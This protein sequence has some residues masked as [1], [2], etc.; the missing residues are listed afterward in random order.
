[1]ATEPE[2]TESSLEEQLVAY[3]D[4]ELDAE[5]VR[6]I[7]ERLATE[8]EV[9]DA[10]NRLERTWDMLDELGSTP[11]GES[12][13]RTTLEMVTVAAEKDVEQAL[14]KVPMRR[15][16]RHWLIGAGILSAVVVGFFAVFLAMPNANRQLLEDL[17][18]I[19]NL[20]EYREVDDISFLRLMKEKGLSSTF[21]AAENPVKEPL[22]TEKMTT[23]ERTGWL[24]KLPSSEKAAL[25]QKKGIFD[26]LSAA[27][28]ARLRELQ[29][30]V[31]KDKDSAELSQ[32]MREYCDWLKTLSPYQHNELSMLSSPEERVKRIGQFAQMKQEELNRN[33]VKLLTEQDIAAVREW[34]EDYLNKFE[35]RHRESLTVEERKKWDEMPEKQ[36]RMIILSFLVG[37]R[38]QGG[39]NKL[40]QLPDN[41]ADLAAKLSPEPRKH[42]ESKSPE[43]QW[44]TIQNWKF[45]IERPK[46][47]E[48]RGRK[49]GSLV[50]E[51][52]IADF[53]EHLDGAEKTRLLNLPPEEMQ[54][55]LQWMYLSRKKPMQGFIDR[56]DGP[57]GGPRGP[58]GN[59]DRKPPNKAE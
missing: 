10:L 27:E 43:E 51:N 14:A 18:L 55:Q 20:D 39:G 37:K 45:A 4:G 23:A 9:R 31:Q 15:R 40:L 7:E 26:N 53:F 13:T 58:R 5:S 38:G 3:L 25:V 19:E 30:A 29:K 54:H 50:N 35:A 46:F 47:A 6:R 33:S 22:P 41:L 59:P 57:P 36:R 16:R 52:E 2:K 1:M 28:Q 21:A 12:F 42:L 49:A 34:W 17:P 44:R 24:D 11:V 8:P 56:P 48:W 32:I